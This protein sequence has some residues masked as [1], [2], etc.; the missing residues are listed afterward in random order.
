MKGELWQCV[1]GIIGMLGPINIVLAMVLI[2]TTM[3]V[4][5]IKKLFG[6]EK[7]WVNNHERH[8]YDSGN[9]L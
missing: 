8:L 6:A 1:I 2:K 5:R 4:F 3:K 9:H 7:W